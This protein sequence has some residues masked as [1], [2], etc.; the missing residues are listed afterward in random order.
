MDAMDELVDR[1]DGFKQSGLIVDYEVIVVDDSIRLR[2]VAPANQDP[3]EVRTFV[4]DALSGLVSE[5][6]IQVDAQTA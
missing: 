3:G 2:L 5:S 6:Q 4:A 1:L